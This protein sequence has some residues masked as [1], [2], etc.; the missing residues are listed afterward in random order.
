VLQ[1]IEIKGNRIAENKKPTNGLNR[2]A[3]KRL[4]GKKRPERTEGTEKA[5]VRTNLYGIYFSA[6]LLFICAAESP[7]IK[8]LSKSGRRKS[9]GQDQG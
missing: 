5:S 7:R 6:L 2:I 4:D 8:R 1:D 3:G 9:Y